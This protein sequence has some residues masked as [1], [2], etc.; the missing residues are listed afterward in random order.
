MNCF[1]A[2]RRSGSCEDSAMGEIGRDL[3]GS[4]TDRGVMGLMVG[5][6]SLEVVGIRGR[7]G[8]PLDIGLGCLCVFAIVRWAVAVEKYLERLQWEQIEC[9]AQVSNS[10][11][12]MRLELLF[13]P[14]SLSE[15]E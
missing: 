10:S 8:A 3:L 13:S 7:T 6:V 1:D 11:W 12:E 14:L 5:I 2:R 15:F 4:G 9:F